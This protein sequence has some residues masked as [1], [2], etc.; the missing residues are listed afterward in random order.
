[1][2]VLDADKVRALAALPRLIACLQDA[3][4]VG[5]V[6]PGRQI[7]RLPGS[8]GERLLLLMPAF[9]SD[10]AGVAK[11]ATV[12]PDKPHQE[13]T[14]H[15]S[16]HRGIRLHRHPCGLVG[17]DSP[18]TPSDWRSFRTGLHLFISSG[19]FSSRSRWHRRACSYNRRGSLHRTPHSAGYRLGPAGRASGRHRCSDS[20][21][22]ES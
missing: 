17:W 1:V 7:A 3:F 19:Q 5:C 18:H 11:L 2:L 12:F 20:V 22:R 14:E 6:S 15:P 10:G 16:N 8:T 4:R 9:D 21:P 13:T